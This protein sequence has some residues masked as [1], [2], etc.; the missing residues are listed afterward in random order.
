L[1]EI[2]FDYNHIHVIISQPPEEKK[3]RRLKF[4][5]ENQNP[6]I[7][8]KKK[9]QKATSQKHTSTNGMYVQR[10]ITPKP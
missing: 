2:D 7:P 1:Y 6:N 4:N 9:F 5:P 10:N 8:S 3:E